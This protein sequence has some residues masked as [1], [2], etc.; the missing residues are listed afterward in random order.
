[1]EGKGFAFTADMTY[2]DQVI[3]TMAYSL[4]VSGVVGLQVYS[5]FMLLK[6]MEGPNLAFAGKLSLL[7][8]S[9]CNI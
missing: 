7:T 5:A 8:L 1:M 6:M 2:Y 3:P 9:L 4:Y